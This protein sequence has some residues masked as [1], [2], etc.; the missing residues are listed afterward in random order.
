[1]PDQKKSLLE[2]LEVNQLVSIVAQFGWVTEA[3]EVNGNKVT[4]RL[5]REFES[6][7]GPS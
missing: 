2:S 1:M 3:K 6:R 4:L 5:V 7:N